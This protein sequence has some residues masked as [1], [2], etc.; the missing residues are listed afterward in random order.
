METALSKH[1]PYA[2]GLSAIHFLAPRNSRPR[3]SRQRSLPQKS[4]GHFSPPPPR[5]IKDPKMRAAL[6]PNYQLGCKR[7]LVSDDFYPALNLPNVELVTDAITE[8]RGHSIVTQDGVER[9]VDVL[10]YG[11]G[12]RATEP[13]I[14]CR[15]VGR[16]GVEIHDAWGKRMTAYLGV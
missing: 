10:I 12:F 7:V 14:G 3:L 15:V 9:P 2:L 1:P 6:T 13:L 8:V 5:R 4:R 16:G 11:T